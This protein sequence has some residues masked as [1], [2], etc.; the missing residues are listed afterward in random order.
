V[1]TPGGLGEIGTVGSGIKRVG[2][3]KQ[4]C[5]TGDKKLC[6]ELDFYRNNEALIK[7]TKVLF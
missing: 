4:G 6:R 1:L 3:L 5:L 7:E 2:W